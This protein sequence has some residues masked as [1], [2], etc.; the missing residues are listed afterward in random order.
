MSQNSVSSN[1]DQFFVRQNTFV[2]CSAGDDV[3]F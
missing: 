2:T 1:K 3:F